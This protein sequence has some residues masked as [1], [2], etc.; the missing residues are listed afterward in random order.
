M[1]IKYRTKDVT[2]NVNRAEHDGILMQTYPKDWLGKK[3]NHFEVEDLIIEFADG[4]RFVIHPEFGK[5]LLER[6][7]DQT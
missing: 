4:I 5:R 1:S 3:E 6:I 2:V 7:D